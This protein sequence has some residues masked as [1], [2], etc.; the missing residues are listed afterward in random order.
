MH[1]SSDFRAGRG[2]AKS[3]MRIE[4]AHA[5]MVGTSRHATPHGMHSFSSSPSSLLT[6]LPCELHGSCL[7]LVCLLKETRQL[8]EELVLGEANHGGDSDD[9]GRDDE[10]EAA[11]ARMPDDQVSVRQSCGG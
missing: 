8:T 5:W 9:D 7:L 2:E 6:C 11:G 1:R 4:R 3:Q 10:G